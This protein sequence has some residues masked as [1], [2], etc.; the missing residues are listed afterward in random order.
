ME[1]YF[2]SRIK[3]IFC[4]IVVAG[5]GLSKLE[6]RPPDHGPSKS[7][8]IFRCLCS[9]FRLAEIHQKTD[10]GWR[11]PTTNPDRLVLRA[12]SQNELPESHFWKRILA[13]SRSPQLQFCYFIHHISDYLESSAINPYS[14]GVIS[15]SD[16]CIGPFPPATGKFPVQGSETLPSK[17][18]PSSSKQLSNR[19]AVS[20]SGR[21][22]LQKKGGFRG[23]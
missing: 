22:A 10:P 16:H 11:H 5:Y 20:T 2:W 23:L 3:V 12:H 8:H 6:G 9:N 18:C 7:R 13:E 17:S 4:I 15:R 21:I 19:S 1:D 14:F